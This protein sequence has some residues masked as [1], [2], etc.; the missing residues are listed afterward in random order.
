MNWKCYEMMWSACSK[1]MAAAPAPL[2]CFSFISNSLLASSAQLDSILMMAA[3]FHASSV[4]V[5]GF[6]RC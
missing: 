4:L 1:G 3:P 2:L 5:N 6:R